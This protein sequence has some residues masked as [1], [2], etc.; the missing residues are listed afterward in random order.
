MMACWPEWPLPLL[1]VLQLRPRCLRVTLQLVQAPAQTW[2]GPGGMCRAQS[3]RLPRAA[4]LQL[5]GPSCD[6]AAAPS[7]GAPPVS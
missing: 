4:G 1:M 5:P 7:D 2:P 6:A 3:P